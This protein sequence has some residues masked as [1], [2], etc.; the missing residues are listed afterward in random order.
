[1]YLKLKYLTRRICKMPNNE[2]MPNFNEELF[3]QLC[4]EYNVEFSNEYEEPVIIMNGGEILP[5]SKINESRLK[6]ILG[7]M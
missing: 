7:L 1:M 3:L 5:F 6:N 4:K 2:S